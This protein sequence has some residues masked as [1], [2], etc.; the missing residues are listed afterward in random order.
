MKSV[1]PLRRD[2]GGGKTD[3]YRSPT[4]GHAQTKKSSG[5]QN[6]LQASPVLISIETRIFMALRLQ[7]NQW[8]SGNLRWYVARQMSS[9]CWLQVDAFAPLV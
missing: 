3:T 5:G 7:S 6:A 1:N 9:P 8:H 2:D 4:L